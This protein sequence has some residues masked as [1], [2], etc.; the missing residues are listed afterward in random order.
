[1]SHLRTQRVQ[2]LHGRVVV[3]KTDDESKGKGKIVYK[4][5]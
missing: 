3:V 5:N 2:A 4:H 1:M